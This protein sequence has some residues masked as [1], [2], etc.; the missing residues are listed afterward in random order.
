MEMLKKGYRNFNMR[1]MFTMMILIAGFSWAILPMLLLRENYVFTIHDGL[2]SYGGMVQNIY[3][4]GLYFHMNQ[5]MPFMHGS[6]GKY[7]FITYNLYDFYNCVFGYVNGQILTR[8][9]GVFLGFFSM[10]YLLRM[11]E[12]KQDL[13]QND[14]IDLIS[15]T[16]IITP[17]APNRMI[18]FAALPA[19]IIL[20]IYLERQDGFSKYALLGL[21]VPIFSIFDT[22]LVFVLGIWFVFGIVV[23]CIK[24]RVNWNLNIAFLLQCVSTIIVNWSFFTVTLSPEDT[25]RVLYVQ[26][27]P[28]DFDPI[29]LLSYLLHGQYH[30]TALQKKIL[31]PFLALGTVYSLYIVYKKTD[32][33]EQGK[34]QWLIIGLWGY[35]FFSALIKTMQECGLSFGILLIDGFQWGR[36]VE[37]MKIGWYIMFACVLFLT[38]RN[39]IWQLVMYVAICLQLVNVTITNSDYNDTYQSINMYVQILRHG[40]SEAITYKD[41]FDEEL[42]DEIKADIDYVQEG[43]AAYGFHPSVLMGNGFNTVDGYETVHSMEW[44]NQFREIIAPQLDISEDNRTYYDGW[45]GRMYLFGALD[46]SPTKTKPTEA[47]PLYINTEAFKKYGGQYIFSRASISNAEELGL[48]FMKD[49]DSDE[50]MYHIYVYR[51][52]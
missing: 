13:F 38:G 1:H 41:F 46:Y 7:T 39:K 26:R 9:T 21:L 15:I 2:D 51:A 19:I 35:W 32:K 45:G 50:S 44:Q 47:Y 31:L 6:Q 22:I 40:V 30:A 14:M 49:Y 36:A 17:V 11:F 12:V 37:L 16:Y 27:S 24:K 52:N 23:Q 4:N 20:F 28:F 10:R 42:F 5:A 25:S 48:E 18:G 8:I 29:L 3:R 43:V 33:R 34:I